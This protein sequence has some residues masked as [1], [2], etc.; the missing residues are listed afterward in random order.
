M[1]FDESLATHFRA[2]SHPRRAA[3]YRLLTEDPD[4]GRT[5]RSLQIASGLCDASLI[6]HLR[7]MERCGL[8]RRK[9]RGAEVT[10]LLDTADF[11]RALGLAHSMAMEARRAAA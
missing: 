8:I 3:I 7:E 4:I 11:C 5:Y 10:Y 1:T 9:R 6:H 2:V